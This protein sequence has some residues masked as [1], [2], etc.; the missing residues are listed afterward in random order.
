[1]SANP[2]PLVEREGRPVIVTLHAVRR[3]QQR[4]WR[5]LR[6]GAITDRIIREVRAALAAGRVQ[7]HKPKHW[8]LYREKGRRLPQPERFV[9]NEADELGWIV[10]LNP[11]EIVVVTTLHRVAPIGGLS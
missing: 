3:A 11:R 1:M 4:R 8:R 7:D 6:A 5:D 2:Q 9:W 10:K